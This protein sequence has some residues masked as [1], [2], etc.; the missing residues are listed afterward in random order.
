MKTQA[1]PKLLV[2][3]TG[4]DIRWFAGAIRAIAAGTADA[5]TVDALSDIFEISTRLNPV[6]GKLALHVDFA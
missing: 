1:T 5:K 3:H 6:T 2:N 4:A